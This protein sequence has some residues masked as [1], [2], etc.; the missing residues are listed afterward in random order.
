[1]RGVHWSAGFICVS[2]LELS[3]GD[4]D[5]FVENFISL[6]LAVS[7]LREVSLV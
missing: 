1:M 3:Q 6:A 7:D 2:V 4:V 5:F